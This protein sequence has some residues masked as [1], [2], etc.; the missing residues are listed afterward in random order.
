MLNQLYKSAPYKCSKYG[1]LAE[2]ISFFVISNTR[3]LIICLLL[4]GNA[5]ILR[6]LMDSANYAN[7]IHPYKANSDSFAFIIVAMHWRY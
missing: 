2:E 7:T 6:K 5:L 4:S 1:A 3:S